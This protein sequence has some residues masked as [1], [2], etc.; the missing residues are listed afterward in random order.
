MK[1]SAR[2]LI[3][4]GSG[5][6]KVTNNVARTGEGNRNNGMMACKWSPKARDLN[7]Q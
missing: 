6:G 3:T 2:E 4:W 1:E 5:D 7:A